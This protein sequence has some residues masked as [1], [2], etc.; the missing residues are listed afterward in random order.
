M[1]IEH[2]VNFDGVYYLESQNPHMNPIA[3]RPEL[4]PSDY[5]AWEDTSNGRIIHFS[6]VILD[7]QEL[8][9]EPAQ[10]TVP[11]R[12]EFIDTK[13][14]SFKLVKITVAL[15]NEKLKGRV[16]GG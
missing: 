8:Q 1:K 3:I 13:G 14:Q 12:I 15:F 7:G 5:A 16:A 4:T 9:A 6:K 10:P 11:N 2:K